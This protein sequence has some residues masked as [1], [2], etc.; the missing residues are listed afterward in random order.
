MITSQR[1]SAQPSTTYPQSSRSAMTKKKVVKTTTPKKKSPENAPI[2]LRSKSERVVVAWGY[3]M[4]V[5]IPTC[6]WFPPRVDSIVHDDN[7]KVNIV[8]LERIQF[9]WEEMRFVFTVSMPLVN[10]QSGTWLLR[11]GLGRFTIHTCWTSCTHH[12]LFLSSL[13]LQ[14][15]IIWSI[16]VTKP[17]PHGKFLFAPRWWH[18]SGP[19]SVWSA[20][21]KLNLSPGGRL[22]YRYVMDT[23]EYRHFV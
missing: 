20:R 12:L 22:D 14:K 10:I 8:A 17:L 23:S 16:L 5:S 1:Y 15:H 2:F 18:P 3:V 13:P 21:G 11:S 6:I 7:R 4:L 9:G 19:W